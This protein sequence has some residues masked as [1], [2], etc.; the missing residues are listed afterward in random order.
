MREA[1]GQPNRV[2]AV[3]TADAKYAV[4]LDPKGRADSEYEMYDLERDPDETHNL[5]GV[6][7]GPTLDRTAARQHTELAERLEVAMDDADPDRIGRRNPPL[8]R[9]EAPFSVRVAHCESDLDL[10]TTNRVKRIYGRARDRTSNLRAFESRT[11]VWQEA[12]LGTE[13]D[14]TDA[15]R[16]RREA[17]VLLILIAGV[18]VVFGMRHSIFPD[19]SGKLVRYGTA[20]SPCDPRLAARAHGRSRPRSGPVPAHAARHGGGRWAS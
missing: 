7:D 13:I 10:A 4:Y 16:A 19:D 17:V 20:I 18:L 11:Q 2:R 15:R 12:G 1:L 6:G 5:V 8:S 14:R 9:T 3:R